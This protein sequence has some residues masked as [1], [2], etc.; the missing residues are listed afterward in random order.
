MELFFYVCLFG[1]PG[2]IVLLATE[3]ALCA[4]RDLASANFHAFV[5]VLCSLACAE[6]LGT[7]HYILGIDIKMFIYT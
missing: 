2:T 1:T 5:G 6:R 4:V 7:G 3:C